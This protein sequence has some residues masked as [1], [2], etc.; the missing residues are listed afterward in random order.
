MKCKE[1][2]IQHRVTAMQIGKLRKQ[3]APDE[4]GDVSPETASLIHS[5]FDELEDIDTRKEMEE[6]V[7]PQF[8]DSICSYAQEGRNEVECK[9]KI[10]GKIHTV[11]SL[12]P[13]M[14]DPMQLRGKAMRLEVIEYK[15]VEYYRHASLAGK[16]WSNLQW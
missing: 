15:G 13:F 1:L 2:A 4:T 9:L 7:K 10:N 16:A 12:I 5:Y 8:V 11:R 3:F 14:D 6:A